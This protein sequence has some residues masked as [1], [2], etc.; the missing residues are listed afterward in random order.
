VGRCWSWR[1]GPTVPAIGTHG[2]IS[3]S[4]GDGQYVERLKRQLVE[5]GLTV[6]TDGG[7]GYG[8]QWPATIAT[9]IDG[10]AAFVPLTS[11]RSRDSDSVR[12]EILYAQENDK[13]ILPCCLRASASSN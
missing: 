8:S 1:P 4:H 3:Y 9:Q 7:I 13:P 2:F 6:W 11:P 5:A 12:K 10:C